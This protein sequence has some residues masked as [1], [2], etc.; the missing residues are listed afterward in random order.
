M[1]KD[2]ISNKK[3]LTYVGETDHVTAIFLF[4]ES[5]RMVLA[6]AVIELLGIFVHVGLNLTQLACGP[7]LFH[8]AGIFNYF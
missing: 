6:F 4:A 1:S 7:A 3:L 5:L 2:N 8:D